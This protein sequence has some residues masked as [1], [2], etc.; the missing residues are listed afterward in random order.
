MYEWTLRAHAHEGVDWKEY[1]LTRWR[2]APGAE[3]EDLRV[4]NAVI[5]LYVHFMDGSR[6]LR[7]CRSAGA[8]RGETPFASRVAALPRTKIADNGQ[9]AA[10]PFA[11]VHPCVRLLEVFP[12]GA[13]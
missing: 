1:T 6:R 5:A 4:W 8:V 11:T 10:P 13:S 7:A 2:R 3:R 12:T 9:P